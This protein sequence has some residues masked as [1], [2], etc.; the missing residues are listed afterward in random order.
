AVL[1]YISK[2]MKNTIYDEDN[3]KKTEENL[4]EVGIILNKDLNSTYNEFL[5]NY[6]T[7]IEFILKDCY[8]FDDDDDNNNNNEFHIKEPKFYSYF[9]HYDYWREAYFPNKEV[10]CK[11]GKGVCMF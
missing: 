8:K 2:L 4:K 3:L 9:D 1:S 5:M 7:N 6:V 11:Y 10:P